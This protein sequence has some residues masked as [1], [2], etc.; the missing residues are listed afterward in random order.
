MNEK[1][2]AACGRELAVRELRVRIRATRPR[3]ALRGRRPW[4]DFRIDGPTSRGL[5]PLFRVHG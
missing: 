5:A 2:C 3:D 4:R 1:T